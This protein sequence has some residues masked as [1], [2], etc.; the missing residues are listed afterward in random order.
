MVINMLH[1]MPT[2][3]TDANELGRPVYEGWRPTTI[4]EQ[5]NVNWASTLR[6]MPWALLWHW[7][8]CI[9]L[10]KVKCIPILPLIISTRICVFW[11]VWFHSSEWMHGVAWVAWFWHDYE[12]LDIAWKFMSWKYHEKYDMGNPW[13]IH[14]K[15]SWIFHINFIVFSNKLH[16]WISPGMLKIHRFL[17]FIGHEMCVKIQQKQ[18]YEFHTKI[19][20]ISLF[21]LS[22]PKKVWFSYQLLEY[23]SHTR[24]GMT[25]QCQ[26]GMIFILVY[27]LIIIPEMVW[28]SCCIYHRVGRLYM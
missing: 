10:V 7:H 9:F 16:L 8:T 18:W 25:F 4:T 24:N 22:I 17:E 2:I 1:R 3:E 19:G 14:T 15:L 11:S 20:V 6:V 5:S 26:N 21:T 23:E 13:K 12:N 28:S 27:G